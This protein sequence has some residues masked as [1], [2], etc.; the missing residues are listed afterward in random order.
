MRRRQN[1]EESLPTVNDIAKSNTIKFEPRNPRQR[2][3]A[4]SLQDSQLTIA[5]GPAGTGKTY[6]PIVHFARGLLRGDYQRIVMMRP[7]VALEGEQHGFLPG[8]KWKKVTPWAR[9]MLKKLAK[10]LGGEDRILDLHRQGRI[11]VEPF[12]YLRGDEFEAGEF[13]MIDEAQNCTVGQLKAFTTRIADGAKIA[14]SGDVTQRD[15]KQGSGLSELVELVDSHDIPC[16][17]IEYLEAD[18]ERGDLCRRFVPAWAAAH[19][20]S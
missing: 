14:I 1:S 8:D 4:K 2:F 19:A 9:P 3:H 11:E 17:I 12:T 16:G 6:V 20:S 7:A 10:L 5:I 15:L 13:V 18:I